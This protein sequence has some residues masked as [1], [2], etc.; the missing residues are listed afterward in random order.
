MMA[1]NPAALELRRMQMLSE[2]GSEDNSTTALMLPSGFVTL[3]K[4]LSDYLREH[5]TP[6]RDRWSDMR[7]R[8]LHPRAGCLRQHLRVVRRLQKL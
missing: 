6:A 2:I 7:R 5:G 8:N 3:A 1:D 4:S